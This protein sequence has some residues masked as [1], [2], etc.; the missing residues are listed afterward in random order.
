MKTK[1]YFICPNNKFASG[2]VK[3]IYRQVQILN[4]NGFDAYILHKKIGKREK[5]FN[6][7]VPIL[8]SPSLFKQIKYSYKGKKLNFIRKLI[9]SILKLQSKSIEKNSILIFPEI[10]GP[11][12]YKI[13]PE[14]SKVIFNQN[15][16]YTFS[17]FSIYT[18]Y[19]SNI[20]N[21]PKTLATIVASDD[22]QKYMNYSF[23]QLKI[24]KMRLGIDNL[25]FNYYPNKE[26]QICFM[27]RKLS[28]D[29]NQVINILHGRNVLK[30][31]NLVSIDNKTETEVAEIMKKS[32]IF[33]SFNHKEGFGLPPVEAMACGCYVIGYTGQGGKEYFKK[34][35]SRHVEDGNIIEFVKKIEEAIKIYEVNPKEILEKGKAASEFILEN[36]SLEHETKDTMEIW[37]DI[38]SK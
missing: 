36:Y 16:Y 8:Y 15:C 26:R 24:Y 27:P 17:Y 14:I 3:Q 37:K 5:W 19:S 2:G 11:E 30:N 31:W 10:Y 28:D 4:N 34:D 33:L 29:V 32:I 6:V 18:D 20:Y 22:A 35:F 13:E 21:H 12:I 1:L 25:I 7:N 9:I 23:P 38:I